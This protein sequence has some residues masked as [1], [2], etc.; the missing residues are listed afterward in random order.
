MDIGLKDP[1]PEPHEEGIELDPA[2]PIRFVWSKTV[3]QSTHNAAMKRRIIE[4][5]IDKRP[6]M[7]KYVPIAD[8][9]KKKL[10]STFDQAFKTLK[11]KWKTQT[12]TNVAVY[13]RFREDTKAMKSRRRERKKAVSKTYLTTKWLLTCRV[14]YR[15]K[16]DVR[17]DATSSTRLHT[18]PSTPRSSTNVCRRKSRAMKRPRPRTVH[19]AHLS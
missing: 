13:Q 3:K 10:E 14:T 2:S 12:N 18:L 15:N 11:E 8:F 19:P 1:L 4:D 6:T 5:I 7:Y 16:R 17:S 9:D